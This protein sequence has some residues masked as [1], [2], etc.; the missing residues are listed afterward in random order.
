MKDMLLDLF[1]TTLRRPGE[2]ARR[3]LALDLSAGTAWLAAGA[4]AC[5]EAVVVQLMGGVTLHDPV[6]QTDPVP[7]APTML[8]IGVLVALVFSSL[9][10]QQVGGLLR[11]K[12]R[13]GDLLLLQSWLQV[14]MVVLQTAVML[15]LILFPVIGVLAALVLVP[16][17]LVILACF[18]REAHGFDSWGRTIA[19]MVLG[20]LLM[21]TALMTIGGFLGS[22][23]GIQ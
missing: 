6:L 2:A 10:F 11:G 12:A 1:V 17:S 15:L 21:A 4:V 19:T 8:A 23:G 3:I 5:A 14:V 16:V 9:A 22:V 13:F 18:V 7:V 20:A